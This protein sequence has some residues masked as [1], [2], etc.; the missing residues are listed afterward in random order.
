[1]FSEQFEDELS[2]TPLEDGRH[3]RVTKAFHYTS[4]AGLRIEIPEGFVTDFAS[5]PFFLW[6]ILP[7]TGRYTRAALVHDKLYSDHRRG[8]YHYSRAFA[9]AVLLEACRDC[10][11]RELTCETIWIGVRI[12]GWKAWHAKEQG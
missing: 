8:V 9:D 2:V 6:W 12:G 4:D 1:M 3:W 5:T 11:C 7:P 10:K